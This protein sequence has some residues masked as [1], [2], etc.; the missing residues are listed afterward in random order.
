MTLQ[1]LKSKKQAD[2]IY[3]NKKTGQLAYT[4]HGYMMPEQNGYYK[5]MQGAWDVETDVLV[6]RHFDNIYLSLTKRK[7]ERINNEE[8]FKEYN[9]DNS[10]SKLFDVSP[11][12]EG[13]R[14]VYDFSKTDSKKQE[15]INTLKFAIEEANKGKLTEL[16]RVVHTLS[17]KGI[18]LDEIEDLL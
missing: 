16:I 15:Q 9:R 5:S 18:S 1:T 2:S 12:K 17:R 13:E 6:C 8:E 7:F 14:E 11:V 4:T 10:I 3:I